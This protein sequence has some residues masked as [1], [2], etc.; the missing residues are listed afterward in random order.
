[1]ICCCIATSKGDLV[2]AGYILLSTYYHYLSTVHDVVTDNR[3]KTK[4]QCSQYINLNPP[5]DMSPA[6]CS[7]Q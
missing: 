4:C 1:M 6:M 3:G 7:Y 2:T 5:C